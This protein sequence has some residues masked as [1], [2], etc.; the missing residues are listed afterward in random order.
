[1]R[2]RLLVTV[3]ALAAAVVAASP[4]QATVST[5]EMGK[6]VRDALERRLMGKAA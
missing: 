2:R 6:A 5:R 3:W 4:G 1:M